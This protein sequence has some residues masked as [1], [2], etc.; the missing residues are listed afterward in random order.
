MTWLIWRQHRNQAFIAA[1]VLGALA[2]ILAITGVRMAATYHTALRAC[3]ATGTCDS[4][5]DGLFNGDGAILDLVNF[6]VLIPLL[7]GLFWGAP[8]FAREIEEGTHMLV[9][10]Q[11]VTRRRWLAAKTFA[12]LCAAL[13]IGAV[14]AV[15]VTWWSR[16]LD[17][18]QHSRFEKFDLQGIVPV[19][20]AIFGAALGLAAGVVI[21]RTLPALAATLGIMAALRIVI[22]N[23]LRPHYMAPLNKL[24]GIASDSG[25][26]GSN[27]MLHSHI[28]TGTGA[29]VSGGDLLSALPPACA[30]Y[31]GTTRGQMYSCLG[32]QGW[33]EQITYQPAN[34][35]WTFQAIESG[36]FVALAV[37][38]IVTA[39]V[40]IRRDA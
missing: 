24:V 23:Y 4:I 28:V 14:L 7:L 39:F 17:L 15:A 11:S 31:L 30:R 40:V 29:R 27:L 16:T 35:F 6:T 12:L 1:C 38:L 32:A 33:K 5:G 34:R 26:S 8:L 36:I 22:A 20:Y 25:I 18:S 10:T 21:R 9:W 19:A 3:G 13:L 37:A 2:I